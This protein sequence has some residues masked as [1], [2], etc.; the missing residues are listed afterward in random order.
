MV[1]ITKNLIYRVVQRNISKLKEIIP[2]NVKFVY[3]GLILGMRV[4]L[5]L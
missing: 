3:G 5:C 2:G 1:F 4:G